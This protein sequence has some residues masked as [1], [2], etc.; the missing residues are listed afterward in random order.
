[1][2]TYVCEKT[3][4]IRTWA[5]PAPVTLWLVL[6]TEE[7]IHPSEML[8][9]PEEGMP[10]AGGTTGD[11]REGSVEA[12]AICSIKVRNVNDFQQGQFPPPF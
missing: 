4:T 6:A 2:G 3:E 9:W 8:K 1:M 12:Q 10:G 11:R 5:L 7:A